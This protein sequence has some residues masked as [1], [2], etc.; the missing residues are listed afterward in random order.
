MK[1]STTWLAT[2]VCS[3]ESVVNRL[4][5]LRKTRAR[6]PQRQPGSSGQSVNGKPLPQRARDCPRR[7]LDAA[8]AYAE[9]YGGGSG[10]VIRH[11]Y[12]V[13]EWGDPKKLAD[14][15]SATKGVVGTTLLGLAVDAGLVKLDDPAVKHYPTI[16]AKR[17]RQ[18]REIGSPR[19]R[20]ATWPR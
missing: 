16:G 2:L 17:A 14:I 9:K 19:S 7:Q 10:C 3:G 20:S 12:L 13:K 11:G 4:G 1:S 6:G 15:K 8:A 18:P 5:T